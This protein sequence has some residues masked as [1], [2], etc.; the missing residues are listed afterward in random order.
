LVDSDESL[1]TDFDGTK[2]L[3]FADYDNDKKKEALLVEV[4][5]VNLCAGTQD[6]LPHLSS[7]TP[8]LA[9]KTQKG[10]TAALDEEEVC[11]LHLTMVHIG[12][13]G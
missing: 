12:K 8:I 5:R 10:L 1:Y 9:V 13:D 6:H 2:K 11:K 7:P 3:V 4:A